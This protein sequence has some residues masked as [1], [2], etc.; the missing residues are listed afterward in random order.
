VARWY[1]CIVASLER[2]NSSRL[3][4]L[5]AIA[6]IAAWGLKA[7]AIGLAGGLD[8]SPLE[9]PL[10][11][12]GLIAIAIAFS[13]LGVAVAGGRS[14]AVKAIGGVLGVLVGLALS[15]LASILAAALIPDS[16][17]WVQEEAGLWLSALL[18]LGVTVFWY[19]TRGA[20]AAL[21]RDAH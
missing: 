11:A 2:V 21:P 15:G 18:A 9:G 12:L 16:A 14:S 17:G 10:F 6:A 3:A 19:T 1:L 13:A 20:A 5:A 4:V 7:L 8:K